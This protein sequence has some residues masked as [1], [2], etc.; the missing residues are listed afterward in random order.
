MSRSRVA[1]GELLEVMAEVGD[2][3]GGPEWMVES[4]DDVAEAMRV[5]LHH[6]SSALDTQFEQD[7]RHPRFRELVTPWRKALG[8]NADARYFDTVIDPGGIYRV[9]G[10]TQGAC[11]VSATL[12]AG[13]ADGSFPS[14][15]VG[16]INDTSF[17]V[18]DD[19]TFSFMVGGPPSERNWLAM[20]PDAS[21]MTTRHYWEAAESPHAAPTADLSLDIELIGGDVAESP[22]APTDA[23]IAAS[24]DRVT[25]YLRSRTIE[26]IMRPGEGEPPAFVSREPNVFP[27]PVPPGDHALAAADASYSMAPF[28][29]DEGMALVLSGRWPRCRCANVSLW[30]RQL[31][32]FDYLRHSVSLNRAQTTL[33]DD[34]GF[35]IVLADRDLGV[36]NFLDTEG[37]SFGLVFWRF[38]LPEGPIETPTAEVVPLSDL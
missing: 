22:R 18:G 37:R 31:Q 8:D 24:I 2:R 4:P 38:M 19:G 30:N 3:F 11:Y 14:G 20:D 36:G 26:S 29:L 13:A 35:R 34:G 33:D 27:A 1:F 23:S 32:S 9:T 6:V 10:R 17:D 5:T 12:E 25:R 28:M 21:R 7:A 15:T 16:V